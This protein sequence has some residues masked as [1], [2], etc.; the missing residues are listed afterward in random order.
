V[1][2]GTDFV[3]DD[4][5][6][7]DPEL[8]EA[9]PDDDPA[10]CGGHGTHV[11]GIVGADG[12]VTGVAPEVEFG[13][14]KVFGCTGS[15]S[16]EVVMQALEAALVDGMDVVNLSL[17]QP[18]QWPDYPTAEAADTLVEEGVVVV[19]SIGNSGESG[20]YGAAAPG[21]GAEVIGVASTDN[22]AER[23][24]AAAVEALGRRIGYNTLDAVPSPA[25]GSVTDPLAWLGR[26]CADAASESDVAG[27]AALVERGT[28]TFKEKY[29][30]A[31]EEGATA[32][33]IYNDRPGP[34]G[35]GGVEDLGVPLVAVT[36][37]DG[38]ELRELV[39]N[40]T[41]TRLEFTGG[42][43]MVD[44]PRAGLTSV[45]SSYGPAPDLALKPDL[46]A[47]G[48]GIWSTYPVED[49]SYTSLSGTSMSSPDR[50]SVV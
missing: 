50:K 26:A 25:A 19:A 10:D 42:T 11:A 28:C 37:T 8:A 16:A 15:T 2:T 36:D 3:G 1:V 48:G 49:G 31:V 18:F 45:F 47:P 44:R 30:R 32:V 34:F 43:V 29:E 17:G 39:E 40:G 13:A 21:I 22:P 24:D 6:A 38:A 5:D 41:E 12:E 27:R 20:V 14:Y 33:V 46:S 7:M 4:Y 9:A 23:M 35:G